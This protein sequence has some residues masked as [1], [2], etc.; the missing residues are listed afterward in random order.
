MHSTTTPITHGLGTVLA[1]EY[2]LLDFVCGL[3]AAEKGSH[4]EGFARILEH[5]AGQL[6]AIIILL[7]RRGRLLPHPDRFEVIGHGTTLPAQAVDAAP[8]GVAQS[9]GNLLKRNRELR[10]SIEILAGQSGHPG[11]NEAGLREAM[12]RHEEME[13]MLTA[14]INEDAAAG[15]SPGAA[16][17]TAKAEAVWENEGGQGAQS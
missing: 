15:R 13:W 1:K 11:E 16:G 8:D 9:L 10:Q 17:G 2:G 7:E 5:H 12:Q 6:A 4:A 14:L 3:L